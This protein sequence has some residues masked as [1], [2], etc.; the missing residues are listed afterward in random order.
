MQ[1]LEF[2]KRQLLIAHV[3]GIPVRIDYR[4]FFVLVV[5]SWIT[6]NNINSIVGNILTSLF[7]GVLT[8]LVFFASIFLHEL[9]HAVVARMEGVQV[10]EI[11]L[12]PFGGLT[13]L[14]HEPETPR[15]EFR[16]AIAGPA[17][18]FLLALLFLGVMEITNLLGTNIITPLFFLLCLMNFLLAVFNLFPGYPL[19]GGR[20]LRAYL[21]RRG[22]DLN[23]ATVLT[24]RCGQIIAVA[25]FVFGLFIAFARG[26]FFTGLWT[27]LVGL[28]L[29]DAAR[30]I[31]RQTN[32]LEKI[33]V[34]D[35]MKLPIPVAPEMSVLEFVDRILPLYRYIV[36]PVAGNQQ[37]YGILAL[38]DLKKLPRENWNKTKIQDVMR[39]ITPDYF[40][41]S[42]ALLVE[43]R[44]LMRENGIGALGVIDEQGNLVGFMHSKK[45]KRRN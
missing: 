40:V 19:D 4:W 29:Y 26:D 14:R 45:I 25:L 30:A 1:I 34:K 22:T 13:R 41:E 27:G 6:A 23:E 42:D 31:I 10:V 36:F 16:I 15:A 33:V 37:L 28:F 24:G 44:A 43:A 7:F 5:L 18:S 11:V 17:A 12:H 8:T 21:W 20:L 38:E 9:A 39:P 2:F 35:V 3:Y 32:E